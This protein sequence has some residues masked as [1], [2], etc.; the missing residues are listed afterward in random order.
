MGK[1]VGLVGGMSGR[2]GNLVFTNQ[3]GQQVVAVRAAA[4]KESYTPAQ[5]RTR[6]R[7]AMAR[8]VSNVF[9]SW[10]LVGLGGNKMRRRADLERMLNKA[11]VV[12]EDGGRFL[13][14]LRSSNVVLSRGSMPGFWSRYD[15]VLARFVS[16]G[17][18]DQ[19]HDVPVLQM[20]FYDTCAN[21]NMFYVCLV[22]S[23]DGTEPPRLSVY[24]VKAYAPYP[25]I[26]FSHNFEDLAEP[27]PHKRVAYFWVVPFLAEVLGNPRRD[28]DIVSN[29]D[30]ATIEKRI[31]GMQKIEFGASWVPKN[32]L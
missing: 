24:H 25:Q 8:A 3:G 6:F 29:V 11:I 27:T 5:L 14:S 22:V 7:F 20:Q 17:D 15:S 23:P 21:L 4:R 16:V 18:G 26:T 19:R 13:G 12:T 32:E 9:P 1:S 10:L 28:G 2:V 30:D 31:F